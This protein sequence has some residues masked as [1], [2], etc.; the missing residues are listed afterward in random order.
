MLIH[1]SLEQLRGLRLEGM[2]RAF[3]E[4]LAHPAA[5]TL[6]FEERLAQ[7]IDRE[8]LLRDGKRVDRLLKAARIK[9]GAA[10]PED[11]DYRAGRGLER[12]QFAALATCQWIRHHQNCLIT[13]PTGSGKTWLA[14]AL[15]NAACRQGLSAYYVRL[16]RLFEE[17]RIAH[18]DGS[19]GRRLMQLARLD[20]IV[21]DDWGLAAPSAAERSDLLE[22]LDDR[23]GSRSTLITSQLPIEH[24]HAYLGDPTF[25][26]AILD[27]VVHAA[28][29][30]A[31]KGESMRKDKAA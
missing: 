8:L 31:L 13:G 22:L 30:L 15:A 27:R 24:W 5:A 16:P 11:V 28:H 10:C 2:A 9:V 23:V 19:F 18:A 25:A 1:H 7:L 20:L 6:S 14:C 12:S 21:I 26:D 29:K 17:L 4:Q 3:E